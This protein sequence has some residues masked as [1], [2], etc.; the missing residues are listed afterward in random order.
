MK[1]NKILYVLLNI[2]TMDIVKS[3][4]DIDKIKY[5]L[6]ECCFAG[7]CMYDLQMLELDLDE[8]E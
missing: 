1:E 8:V 5:C 2:N 3:S 4:Y 7:I 6:G